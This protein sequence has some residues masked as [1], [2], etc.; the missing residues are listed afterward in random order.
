M[1]QINNGEVASSVRGKINTAITTV[2]NID[3]SIGAELTYF[4]TTGSNN[5]YVITP[6]SEYVLKIGSALRVQFNATNSSSVFTLNFANTGA[7]RCYKNV[8]EP[9]QP[10]EISDSGV[11][12]VVYLGSTWSVVGTAPV[13]VDNIE[14]DS[15]YKVMSARQ[16]NLL[17]DRLTTTETTLTQ[18]TQTVSD[19]SAKIKPPIFDTDVV[20]PASDWVYDGLNSI[21]MAIIYLDGVT[22]NDMPTVLFHLTSYDTMKAA[23]IKAIVANVGK[24]MIAVEIAP[25]VDVTCDVFVQVLPSVAE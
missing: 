12:F 4:T 6:E 17:H 22:I 16:V 5:A 25:T 13:V 21:Y 20:I 15:A 2:E 7:L 23:N 1:G 8:D 9:I 18:T 11:Y 10:G 3:S 14:D 24:V 19:I